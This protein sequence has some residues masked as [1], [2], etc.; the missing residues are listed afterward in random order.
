MPDKNAVFFLRIRLHFCWASL[1]IS[2]RSYYVTALETVQKHLYNMK[3]HLNLVEI[4]ILVRI[5]SLLSS[6]LN[7]TIT[8][9]VSQGRRKV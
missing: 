8:K 9:A 5:D 6:T 1:Y 4:I 3:P 2:G 7:V